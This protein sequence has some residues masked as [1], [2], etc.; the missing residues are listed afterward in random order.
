M[1][2]KCLSCQKIVEQWAWRRWVL[3]SG[4]NVGVEAVEGCVVMGK[5]GK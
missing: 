1:E 5:K 4:G 3:E 2:L